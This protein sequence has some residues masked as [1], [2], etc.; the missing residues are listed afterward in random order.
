M[1]TIDVVKLREE[2][3][4]FLKVSKMGYLKAG[5]E[6]G[7]HHNTFIGFL[8]ERKDISFKTAVKIQD[9]L[10]EKENNKKES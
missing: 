5:K 4:E 6:I 9:W 2:L 7:I 10:E 1:E 3:L 8:D